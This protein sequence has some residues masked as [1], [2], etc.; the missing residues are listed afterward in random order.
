MA[1]GKHVFRDAANDVAHAA[2]PSHFDHVLR[3]GHAG[4]EA[5]HLHDF[6]EFHVFDDVHA[7]P[8]MP[9]AFFIG[10]AAHEL[11]R[12]DS[13]VASRAGIGSQPR[14]VAEHESQTE[15]GNRGD[16]PESAHL[17]RSE[18]AEMVPLALFG[19][20]DG[21]AQ[22]VGREMHVR[23]RKNEPFA[24]AIVRSPRPARAVFPASRAA[25]SQD[26]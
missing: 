25:S 15:I 11:E 2:V 13:H 16:L 8:A 23:I 19:Q 10:G 26:R 22:H 14:L 18:Q 1:R 12:A 9:A 4:P 17:D 6:A 7:Q 21:A 3:H 24:A 5:R 20:R